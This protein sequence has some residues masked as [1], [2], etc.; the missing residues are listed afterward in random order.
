MCNTFLVAESEVT[1]QPSQSSFVHRLASTSTSFNE[2]R[3]KQGA[4]NEKLDPEYSH[5]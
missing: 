4:L 5:S 1:Q 3:S 2:T